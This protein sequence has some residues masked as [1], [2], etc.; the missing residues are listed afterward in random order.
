MVQLSNHYLE[1]CRSYRDTNST[2]KCDRWPTHRQM[3][4]HVRKY[5]T[6]KNYNALLH[7]MAGTCNVYEAVFLSKSRVCNS[8]NKTFIRVLWPLCI[9]TAYI[10]TLLQVSNH[11]L[12][13]CREIA[14][15]QTLL[16]HVYKTNFQSKTR[17][18]NSTNNNLIRILDVVLLMSTL[19]IL[20]CGEINKSSWKHTY[21]ILTPLNP[22]FI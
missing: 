21:I 8:S 2:I 13:N 15:T 10:L 1:N 14:E 6:W 7:F 3:D 9:C 20:F 18:S 12:E 4:A 16:C 17:V 11:Y 22:T 5:D 19:N